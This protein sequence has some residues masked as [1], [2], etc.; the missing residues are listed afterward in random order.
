MEIKPNPIT[1]AFSAPA[2]A[3]ASSAPKK[4]AAAG[5][6]AVFRQ[7][8]SL[9][10]QLE[11]EP[12]VRSEAVRRAASLISQPSWPPPAVLREVSSLLAGHLDRGA[13]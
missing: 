12:S 1:R 10:T 8:D 9:A 5:D 6:S 7:A 2:A 3:A 13:E 11:G 4:A